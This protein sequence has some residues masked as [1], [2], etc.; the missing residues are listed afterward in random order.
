MIIMLTLSMIY[1]TYTQQFTRTID[2]MRIFQQLVLFNR[3]QQ[4]Y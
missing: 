4:L 2:K 1:Q 3:F